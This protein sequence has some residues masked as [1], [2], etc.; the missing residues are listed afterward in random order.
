MGTTRDPATP[1]KPAGSCRK[2]DSGRL[3]TRDGDGHT[4]FRRGNRCVNDA[5]ERFLVGGTVR[6]QP[7]LLRPGA[8][9]GRTPQPPLYSSGVPGCQTGHRAALASR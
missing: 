9:L 8:A 6:G 3:I 7:V 5:V 2:L 1:N 4:G